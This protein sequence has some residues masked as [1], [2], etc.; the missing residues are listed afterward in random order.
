M[1]RR[2]PRGQ[3][4]DSPPATIATSLDYSRRD[5]SLKMTAHWKLP[6]TP[7]TV[8]GACPAPPDQPAGRAARD[9]AD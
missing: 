7:A 5:P 9:P 6:L 8:A 2:L 1:W 3:L 4:S